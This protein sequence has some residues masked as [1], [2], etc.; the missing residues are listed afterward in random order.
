MTPRPW[1]GPMPEP[2]AADL[3]RGWR[4]VRDGRAHA[5][6]CGAH[7]CADVANDPHGAAWQVWRTRGRDTFA[8]GSVH[9]MTLEQA[10][11]AAVEA[12]N[13]CGEWGRVVVGESMCS[14]ADFETA[15]AAMTDRC[16]H[17][18]R[19]IASD[20]D[21][22]RYPPG[23]GD[24]LCWTR[25]PVACVGD[26]VDWR[27]RALAAEA[28]PTLSDAPLPEGCDGGALVLRSGSRVG[29]Y[30]WREIGGGFE[31]RCDVDASGG[32]PRFVEAGVRV[33]G[34][35]WAWVHR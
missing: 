29:V 14:R 7:W 35:G 9:G 28:A 19:P 33:R 24:H 30:H 3:V 6:I 13:E 11:T 27:A 20:E 4:W 31:W 21:A 17:C 32:M 18:N 34:W 23:E 12:A 26:A 16:E 15:A 8:E 5:L 22:A 10:K 2:S 1:K 25:D